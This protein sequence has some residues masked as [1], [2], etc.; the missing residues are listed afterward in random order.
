VSCS[1]TPSKLSAYSNDHHKPVNVTATVQ[2]SGS[3]DTSGQLGAERYRADR[4]YMLTYCRKD[5][6]SNTAD[7]QKT[8][9]VPKG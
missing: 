1:V 7:C 3:G 8:V 2:V 5:I 4:I 9:T 6:A